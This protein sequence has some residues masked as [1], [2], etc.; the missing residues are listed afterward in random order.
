VRIESPGGE[1]CLLTRHPAVLKV[2]GDNRRAPT[3]VRTFV[4]TPELARPVG[5]RGHRRP[6]ARPTSTRSHQQGSVEKSKVSL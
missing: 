4:C 6:Q 2:S 5:I 1:V 3:G